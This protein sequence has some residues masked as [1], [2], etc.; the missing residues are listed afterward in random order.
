MQGVVSAVTG[1]V[2]PNAGV[3]RYV[4]KLKLTQ[5]SR[6]D[7]YST[8]ILPLL[9]CRSPVLTGPAATCTFFV[10]VVNRLPHL[11]PLAHEPLA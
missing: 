2:H 1:V 7:V 6:S 10:S 9:I 11:A 5:L 3:S 8:D 4:F